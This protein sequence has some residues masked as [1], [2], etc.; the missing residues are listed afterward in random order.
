MALRGKTCRQSK[1]K[2]ERR[3]EMKKL[4][5]LLLGLA[6]LFAAACGA[7]EEAAE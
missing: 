3:K 7:P 2:G 6:L 4:L 1:A 5:V